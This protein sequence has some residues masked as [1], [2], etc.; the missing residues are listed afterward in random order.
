M[1]ADPHW[2]G[3]RGLEKSVVFAVHSTWVDGTNGDF[4]LQVRRGKK[5]VPPARPVSC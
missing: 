5:N 2:I 1:A 4:A 3:E